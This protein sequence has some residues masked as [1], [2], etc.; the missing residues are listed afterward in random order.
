MIRLMYGLLCMLMLW[1][2]SLRATDL[3]WFDG[4]VDPSG[5][6]PGKLLSGNEDYYGEVVHTGMTYSYAEAP[7][8]PAE[9]R[10]NREGKPGRTLVNGFRGKGIG[11][12]RGK[13][14][15]LTCDFRHECVFTEFDVVS[16]SKKLALK[17]EISPDGEQWHTLFEQSY[18]DSPDALLHRIKLKDSP[19]GRYL[20]LTAQVPGKNTLLDE[21]IAWGDIPDFPEA[22]EVFDAPANGVYPIGVAYPTITGVGKSAVSDREAFLWVDALTPEQRAE[23]A[24][25]FQVPT[26]DSISNKPLLPKSPEVGVPIRI[27]MARNEVEHVA[28]ALKNTLVDGIRDLTIRAPHVKTADGQTAGHLTA[29]LGVMG[30]I[31]DRGFGNNLGPIFYEGNLLGR[32][33]MVKYL[34]NGRLIRDYPR[35]TL[36]PS[37]AA[38]F[39]LTVSSEN[40]RPGLY[41][42]ELAFEGGKALPVEIEVVDVTLPPV[43]A[44]VKAY[45][46]PSSTM[47]PFVYSDRERRDI[48][49]ELECGI[50]DFRSLTP[51][52]ERE[53]R[54][55]AKQKGMKIMIGAGPL[56]PSKYIHNIYSGTWAKA[57]DLPENAAD[58]IAA[59]LRKVV[60]SMRARGLDYS[61]WY[62]HTGDEPGSKNIGAVAAVC[63]MI[64]EADP[65]VQIYLN[66]CYWTGYDR[67]AVADDET[68]SRDLGGW[69]E[70]DVDISVPLM[71]LL[72]NR[73]ESFK[74]FSAPRT[75][76][77][78]YIV[79][80]HLDRSESAAEV[81]KYRDMAWYSM[82]MNFNG[83]GFY[84]F[85]SPRGNAWNHFDRNPKGEGLREPSD[86]SMVYPGP[87]E[88]V[89][90]RQSEAL[91]QGK[92]DYRLLHLLKQQGQ[93]ALAKRLLERFQQGESPVELRLEALRA[94][95]GHS[96]KKR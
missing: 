85:Y 25:W 38:V 34:L 65:S 94:A 54:T 39:W 50:S 33:L 19:R 76:N 95:V 59:H 45:T 68:V 78:Y 90:T 73:P 24:V 57:E 28:V 66:P 29:R 11:M 82:S 40:A 30:V 8:R 72:R 10:P 79:S 75:V 88:F 53:V 69:Y 22:S 42:T 32:G 35:I 31:G 80:G 21:I 52:L 77:A 46:T 9:D 81:R 61:D 47:F 6:P 74:A 63:R 96:E 67:N 26:W 55:L 36:H 60:E 87:R 51:S 64:R 41:R 86:Y 48:N 92:E 27:V 70:R 91:R 18:Q 14:L 7:D 71:L 56:I 43:F 84:S 89:P 15:M 23:K 44:F 1:T 62:G 5:E 20:R 49:Y 3:I 16:K 4:S 58:E 83:W 2:L 13:P 17:L 12:S 37:A 93:D